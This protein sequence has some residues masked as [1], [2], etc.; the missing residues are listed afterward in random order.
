[1]PDVFTN[2]AKKHLAHPVAI[3]APHTHPF[4]TFCV[5]PSGVTVQGSAADEEVLLILR[6]HFITNLPW[7]LTALFLLVI[8]L[9]ALLLFGNAE[10]TLF[11]FTLPYRY[12]VVFIVFYYLI[13]FGFILVEIMTWYYNVSLVTTKRVVD[14][15]FSDVI[16][17]NVAAT[18]LTLVQDVEY[19]QTGG[20]RTLFNYGDVFVKTASES[21]SF[22]F[23]GVPK[24]SEVTNIIEDLIGER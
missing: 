24:P 17:H 16:Y 8:P 14:I 3:H 2:T 19:S 5:H 1:M 21:Q 9:G 23:L 13:V 11:P 22:D 6:R 15:D 10:S 20:I 12:V 7:I 4:A 18:K